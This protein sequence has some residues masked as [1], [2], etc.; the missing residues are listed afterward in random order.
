MRDKRFVYENRGGLLTKSQHIQLVLWACACAEHALDELV[1]RIDERFENA[2][3]VARDWSEDKVPTAD[4]MRASGATHAAAREF[5]NPVTVAVARAL[6]QAV[7]S[8]H[9]ADHSL[10]AALYAL[11]AYKLAGE[12]MDAERKWQHEQLPPEIKALVLSATTVDKY[13]HVMKE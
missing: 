7:A 13:K 3:Q 5:K 12:S 1:G 8:A 4:A 10:S 9:M 11:K 6:G 2:L